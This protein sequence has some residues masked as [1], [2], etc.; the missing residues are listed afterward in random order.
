MDEEKLNVKFA[1]IRSYPVTEWS[2]HCQE[3]G[4]E[5]DSGY[6]SATAAQ[7]AYDNLL[8]LEGKA[9][10]DEHWDEPVVA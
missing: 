8:A 3:C 7:E 6:R 4:A 1:S 10:C 5:I 9:V 2:T